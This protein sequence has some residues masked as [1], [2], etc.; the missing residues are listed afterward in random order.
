MPSESFV[1]EEVKELFDERVAPLVRPDDEC[2]GD[3]CTKK[4]QNGSI[5]RR[6]ALR[7]RAEEEG[8]KVDEPKSTSSAPPSS[9]FPADS[10]P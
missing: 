4:G 5:E 2:F 3:L 9:A 8:K 10:P 1:R 7:R 6:K